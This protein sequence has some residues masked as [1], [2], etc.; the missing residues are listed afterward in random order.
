MFVRPSDLVRFAYVVDRRLLSWTSALAR[1]AKISL[2]G[3]QPRFAV[4]TTGLPTGRHARHR[5]RR[6]PQRPAQGRQSRARPRPAAAPAEAA[7]RPA[8]GGRRGGARRRWLGV[9]CGG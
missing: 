1:V 5:R 9:G 6:R 7:R 3:H 4:A 8:G 2:M